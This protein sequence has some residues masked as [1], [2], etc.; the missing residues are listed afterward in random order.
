MW[1]DRKAFSEF[2]Q[3]VLPYFYAV[4]I[5]TNGSVPGDFFTTRSVSHIGQRMNYVHFVVDFKTH[6]SGMTDRMLPLLTF[7]TS[8]PPG[9][10]YKFVIGNEK[11]FQ[12]ACRMVSRM[13]KIRRADRFAFSACSTTMTHNSLFQLMEEKDLYDIR[14]NV[15]IHKVA[16]LNERS[17]AIPS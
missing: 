4:Q 9:T 7:V 17:L 11:D 10:T 5:E 14:L 12:Q 6:S 16:A 15:Q 8:F 13:K 2:I 1:Q 3:L